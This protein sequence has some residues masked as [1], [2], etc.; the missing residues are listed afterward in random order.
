MYYIQALPQYVYCIGII[1]KN[2]K[3]PRIQF[4]KIHFNPLEAI[5]KYFKTKMHNNRLK[6]ATKTFF[7]TRQT[8]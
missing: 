8:K 3:D 1:N 7:L 6:S 4:K 5:N 2:N